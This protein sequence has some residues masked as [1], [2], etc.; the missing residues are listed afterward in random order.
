[1]KLKGLLL[2]SLPMLILGAV[3]G[4]GLPPGRDGA[5]RPTLVAAEVV[6]VPFGSEQ[7]ESAWREEL[8]ARLDR[9]ADLEAR[10]QDLAQQQANAEKIKASI[11]SAKVSLVT[12][13]ASLAEMQKLNQDTARQRLIETEKWVQSAGQLF[14]EVES[15]LQVDRQ[16]LD[17]L[18]KKFTEGLSQLNTAKD[19]ADRKTARSELG[20]VMVQYNS[21]LDGLIANLRSSQ[22]RIRNELDAMLENPPGE[23]QAN[24]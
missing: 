9:R 4:Y 24:P 2:F 15:S 6:L 8:Q 3:G 10:A 1:M 12:L 21:A 14:S 23:S 11:E 13:E 20:A 17:S 22:E 5:D 19:F 16:P 7:A 18:E